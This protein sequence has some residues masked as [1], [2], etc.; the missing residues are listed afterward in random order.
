MSSRLYLNSLAVAILVT[1]DWLSFLGTEAA[2][3]SVSD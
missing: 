3:F 1:S 2:F